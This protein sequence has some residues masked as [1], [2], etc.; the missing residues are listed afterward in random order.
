MA[1]TNA[2]INSF[3]NG[4]LHEVCDRLKKMGYEESRRIRIYGEEF[5]LKSNPFP[6]GS[7]IAIHAV[8]RR[9]TRTRVVQL[10]LPV[11]QMVRQKKAA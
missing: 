6:Q 8:A 5:E 1:N 4:N 7:G 9:E 11:L 10:P 3:D 2:L